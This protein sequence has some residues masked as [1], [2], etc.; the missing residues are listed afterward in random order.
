M[1]SKSY[2]HAYTIIIPN[3]FMSYP[4]S[5]FYSHGILELSPMDYLSCTALSYS[6]HPSIAC[7]FLLLPRFCASNVV[8]FGQTFC[9][10]ILQSS[11][12]I[13]QNMTVVYE[14]PDPAW[15]MYAHDVAKLTIK[16]LRS[17]LASHK[18]D[19]GDLNHRRQRINLFLSVFNSDWKSPVLRHHCSMTCPCG[20]LPASDLAALAAELYVEIIL[21]SRPPIPALNRWLKCSSTARWFMLL[22]TVSGKGRMQLF[23]ESMYSIQHILQETCIICRLTCL[24][25]SESFAGVLDILAQLYVWGHEQTKTFYR[26]GLQCKLA[27]E[28]TT[29]DSL[30]CTL[31]FV[32]RSPHSCFCFWFM[33]F[34]TSVSLKS[35][36]QQGT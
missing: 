10:L 11:A 13:K 24:N 21:G 3:H 28:R 7:G 8:S 12:F 14:A 36:F 32:V 33:I 15:A 2:P 35:D 23:V 6:V 26:T 25:L 30:N 31:Y 18:Y 20:C 22:A 9:E 4:P 19:P 16:Q 17:D 34:M 1:H 5:R 27:A 29:I